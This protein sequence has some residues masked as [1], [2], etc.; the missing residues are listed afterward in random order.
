MTEEIEEVKVEEV[1]EE[2]KEMTIDE[3]WAEIQE[4][5]IETLEKINR[6]L[7]L[8][9][10]VL[11][12]IRRTDDQAFKTVK[13]ID[14]L[15]SF[16]DEKMEKVIRTNENVEDTLLN[17]LLA[18]RQKEF[19]HAWYPAQGDHLEM[20]VI[21]AHPGKNDERLKQPADTESLLA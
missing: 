21:G 2:V 5:E 10:E 15:L 8:Q 7:R 19:L 16:Y 4:K 17:V 18:I 6:A 14:K 12:K 9:V 20:K 1:K 13:E 3:K 11:E